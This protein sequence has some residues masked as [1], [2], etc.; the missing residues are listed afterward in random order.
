M[1]WDIINSMIRLAL[2]FVVVYKLYEF[3][4][5]A[6]RAEQLGLGLMGGGGLMT[7]PGIWE[8][9]R[10]PFDGYSVT[11]LTFGI[12]LFIMGRTWRDYR[13]ARANKQ[14]INM[15]WAQQLA[16]RGKIDAG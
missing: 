4:Q 11:I 15:A 12:L 10:S 16:N 8:G 6:N 3:R 7:V 14:L 2:V 5:L 9:A 13:H 1:T